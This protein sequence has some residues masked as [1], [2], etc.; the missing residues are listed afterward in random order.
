[1]GPRLEG[2]LPLGTA[3]V[4]DDVVVL[5]LAVGHRAVGQVGDLEQ[6]FPHGV[7]ETSGSVFEALHLGRQGPHL[8]DEVA[9]IVAT[10]FAV[11]DLLAAG[12]THRLLRLEILANQTVFLIGKDQLIEARQSVRQL[13]RSNRPPHRLRVFTNGF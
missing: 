5:T 11:A 13:F 8:V 4:D 2:E 3:L 12:I 10:A 6:Q 1:M 7:V 9:A